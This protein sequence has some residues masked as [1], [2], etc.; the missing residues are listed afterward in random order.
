M[1][2]FPENLP[3]ATIIGPSGSGETTLFKVVKEVIVKGTVFFNNTLASA[4][5]ALEV[6]YFLQS[7]EPEHRIKHGLKLDDELLAMVQHPPSVSVPHI[8]S[9][10]R[11]SNQIIICQLLKHLPLC[12]IQ[13]ISTYYL[14]TGGGVRFLLLTS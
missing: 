4:L 14:A 13:T 11:G 8:S 5:I 9:S 6:L 12:P 3:M 7:T 1:A 2:E 10:I